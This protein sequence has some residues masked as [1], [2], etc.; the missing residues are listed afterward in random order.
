VF[1]VKT[2]VILVTGGTEEYR[3]K[4]QGNLTHILNTC[5][6]YSETGE[7]L[8]IIKSYFHSSAFQLFQ[9]LV[10]KTKLSPLQNHYETS[11]VETENGYYE[12]RDIKVRVSLGKTKGLPYQYLVF[13]IDRNGLIAS[14]HFAIEQHHYQDI[15]QQGRMLKDIANREKILHFIELYR[16]AYNRKDLEFIEK[17]LSEDALIIVGYVIETK[18]SDVDYLKNS[19][20]DSQKIQLI[21]LSKPAY[22]ARLKEVFQQNDFVR[23]EFDTISLQRHPLHDEIYGMQLKQRWN[24]STYSDEG[25][26]FLMIDFIKPKEPI[27]HVR[28]WQ[29][30]RFEDGSTISIYDFEIVQA[31]GF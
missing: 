9:G 26:L 6:L 14:A 4:V 5:D 18:K 10:E 27:I 13:A 2:E 12:V 7:S 20:L 15:I 16:T 31:N 25:Y 3:Q 29:P 21:K 28:A 1:A 22:I 23:V 8:Q 24:S 17:T 11:L 19:F 30:H